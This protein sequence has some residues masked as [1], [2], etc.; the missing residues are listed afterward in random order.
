MQAGKLNRR[1]SIQSQTTTDLDAFKQPL[2]S[3]WDTI[4]ECWASISTITGKLIYATANF[5][6]QSS[7]EI[8]MR[9]TSSVIIS[10]KQRVIYTEPTTNV[11]HTYEIEAVLNDKQGNEQLTLLVYEL[12]GEE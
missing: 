10:A 1:I 5:V 11:T 4:Y 7:H 8:K 9:W 3:K 2:P 6:S 12:S